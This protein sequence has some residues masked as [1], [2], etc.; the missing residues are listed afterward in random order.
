MQFH[1]IEL[2]GQRLMGIMQHHSRESG[3]VLT[4][5]R[6]GTPSSEESLE[7]PVPRVCHHKS[8]SIRAEVSFPYSIPAG[9]ENGTKNR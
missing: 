3:R 7:T 8:R 6:L 5:S 4:S 2:E 1:R 9:I